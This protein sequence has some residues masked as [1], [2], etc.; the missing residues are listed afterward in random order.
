VLANTTSEQARPADKHGLRANTTCGQILGAGKYEVVGLAKNSRW[1]VPGRKEGSFDS[2][3]AFSLRIPVPSKTKITLH[4][5][6]PD[7]DKAS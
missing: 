4:L 7:L 3:C 2:T 1:L 5:K 6:M